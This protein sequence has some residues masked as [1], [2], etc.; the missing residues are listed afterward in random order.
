MSESASTPT[1]VPSAMGRTFDDAFFDVDVGTAATEVAELEL[2]L[3]DFCVPLEV[4]VAPLAEVEVVIS[5]AS[6][7]V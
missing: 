1:T 6:R 4:D 3:E 5:L 7:A 2:E